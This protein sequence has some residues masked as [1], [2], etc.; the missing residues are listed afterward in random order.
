MLYVLHSFLQINS[1]SISNQICLKSNI[2][3]KI[4]VHMVYIEIFNKNYKF[5]VKLF[6]QKSDKGIDKLQKKLLF[7]RS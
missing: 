4:E 2:Y 7:I 6:V 3:E 1:H 5:K